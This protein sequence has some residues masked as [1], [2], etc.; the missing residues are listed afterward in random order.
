MILAIIAATAAF[1]S[2]WSFCTASCIE[3]RE[4]ELD[5]LASLCRTCLFFPVFGSQKYCHGEDVAVADGTL[6]GIVG[7]ELVDKILVEVEEVMTELPVE[8]RVEL[9]AV[10]VLTVGMIL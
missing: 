2:V 4:T 3:S 5:A 1:I 7:V 10:V 6:E 9:E 8:M